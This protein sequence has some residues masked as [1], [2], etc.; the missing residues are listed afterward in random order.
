MDSFH[1]GQI[2]MR[3]RSQWAKVAFDR[4]LAALGIVLFFPVLVV[5]AV[6]ILADDGWPVLFTQERI[7]RGFR[8]FRLLKF[9]SM[10][11]KRTG[12]RVT[13]GG[14]PRVTRSG[15]FLRRFK[16]DELPQLWNVIRGE[17]SLVGPRPEVPEYV[18]ASDPAWL[19]VMEVKPGITDLASLV[20]RH[21]EDILSG[22]NNPEQFYRES[23]LPAKLQLNIR[24]LCTASLWLDLRLVLLSI[25]YGLLADKFEP[26][27][28]LRKFSQ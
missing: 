9:R 3:R 11:L 25:R 12:P 28:I 23:I 8:P 14:D 7:G 10:R 18:I 24:Y 19:S 16:L 2:R 27:Q 6:I 20:Y 26:S 4:A 22:H 13:A 17:M 1:L 15:R 21:E 5:L